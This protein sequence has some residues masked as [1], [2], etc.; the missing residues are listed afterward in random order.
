MP[1][2]FKSIKVGSQWDR[3]ALAKLWGYESFHA[4]A[5]GAV[6]PRNDNKVILFI[7]EEKQT[8][9][10]QYEDSLTGNVL[11]IEGENDHRSD[12]R[13]IEAEENGDEIHLFHRQRHHTP[14]T[15]LGRLRLKSYK[16]FSPKPSQFVFA[17]TD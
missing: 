2:S 14:F 7:T 9:A 8:S 11:R 6:T 4:I 1:V 12:R 13:M 3:P 5:K 15:Y 16:Q 17:L 10:T